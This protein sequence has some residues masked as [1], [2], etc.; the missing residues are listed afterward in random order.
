M[1]SLLFLPWVLAAVM[2]DRSAPERA[3]LQTAAAVAAAMALA[4]A[5]HLAWNAHRFG[6]PFDFGY[7]AAETIPQMPPQTIRLGD[8]PR[9]LV[10]LLATP[11]K[12]LL[13]W[14]PVLLLACA[15]LRRFWRQERGI[16][17]GIVA[18]G[19][20]GLGFYAAYLF[21]EAGY[22]HGPR[23]LVPL[24]PL[25]LLPAVARPIGE[26]PRP[27]LIACAAVGFTI[28]LMATSIS[29][30]QDQGL[31]QDL[32]AGARTAYYERIDP[33]PGR[34]W[35]R[36]RLAYVPFVRTLTSG[37]WPQADSLGHGLD[38]F[39]H[40]LSRARHDLRDGAAIPSWLIWVLP[41]AWTGL[42]TLA[43]TRLWPAIRAAAGSWP[44]ARVAGRPA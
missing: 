29:F 31:G 28:A 4:V 21:P 8:I 36:Y 19:A 35:N 26:R 20:T 13:L 30:L 1:T 27:A 37:Q 24:V 38:F 43:V 23:Q 12:S 15:S 44:T 3:R 2:L 17:A 34:P 11:G 41:L 16:A 22:S 5:L 7:D 10:L 18:A 42:L 25:L 32:G 40:H 39:P 14:A 6:D 9:G 33:P